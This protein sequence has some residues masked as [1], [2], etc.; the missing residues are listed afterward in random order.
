MCIRDSSLYAGC[1]FVF[2]GG[3]AVSG[4]GLVWLRWLQD[5]PRFSF[6]GRVGQLPALFGGVLETAQGQHKPDALAAHALPTTHVHRGMRSTPE[7]WD[8][9]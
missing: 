1:L 5:D 2:P 6:R 3:C 7:D 4:G 8:D 9:S